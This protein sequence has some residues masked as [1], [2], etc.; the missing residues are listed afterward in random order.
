MDPVVGI[1][2]F[3]CILL[4]IVIGVVAFGIKV[5]NELVR[6]QNSVEN[7]FSQIDVQLQRR[8]DL[9]PNLVETVKGFAAHE[10][11]LLENV[12]ASRGGFMKATTGEE[13]MAANQQLTS[14]LRSLFVVA[15][16]YPELKA[17]TNFLKLQEE[18]AETEDKVQYSRQFYNDAVTIYNNKRE[19][20][21][22]SFIANMFGFKEE[23][24]FVVQ[25]EAA[26]EAPQ[27]KF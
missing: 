17:N 18:L 11:E 26:K 2:I 5:Y 19:M 9:I 27:V 3:L 7:S 8:F 24:L 1:I 13:K 15:E 16:N 23:P 4:A 10:K 6:L 22:N 14:N 20:F 25:N 21:P 12:T